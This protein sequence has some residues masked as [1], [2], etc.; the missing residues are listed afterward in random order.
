LT[1]ISYIQLELIT[2]PFW[3]KQT[4]RLVDATAV[5]SLHGPLGGTRVIKLYKAVVVALA[6]K[7][8]ERSVLV[9]AGSHDKMPGMG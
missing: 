7:L 8:L 6:V 9:Q 4:N 3:G 1:R 5:Q 2:K